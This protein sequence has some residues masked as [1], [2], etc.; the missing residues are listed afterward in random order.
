MAGIVRCGL[1]GSL[2]SHFFSP[3]SWQ[4]RMVGT[5]EAGAAAPL[6]IILVALTQHVPVVTST[7]A[8]LPLVPTMTNPLGAITFPLKLSAFL[9]GFMP[10][11]SLASA[12]TSLDCLALLHVMF[13]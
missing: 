2:V 5:V 10:L 8:V 11:C 6:A 9:W 1:P 13:I 7:M 3:L 4:K 12:N